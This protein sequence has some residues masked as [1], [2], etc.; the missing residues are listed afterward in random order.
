M[1]PLL[2][3]LLTLA[4]VRWMRAPAGTRPRPGLRAAA[5]VVAMGALTVGQLWWARDRMASYQVRLLG[6][7]F[8][9]AG[10]QSGDRPPRIISGDRATADI[11]V[12][13]IGTRP[14][15]DIRMRA[16]DNGGPPVATL[17]RRQEG[18]LGVVAVRVE[19]DGWGGPR[20]TLL[21]SVALAAGDEIRVGAPGPAGAGG[22]RLTLQ[23]DRGGDRLVVHVPGGDVGRSTSIPYPEGSWVGTRMAELFKRRPSVFQRTYPLTELIQAAHAGD[24]ANSARPGFLATPHGRGLRSFLYY[25]QD[26]P[27]L[28]ALDQGIVVRTRDGAERTPVARHPIGRSPDPQEERPSEPPDTRFGQMIV[29]ALPYRDFPE[30]QLALGERYGIRVQQRMRL[31]VDPDWLTVQPRTEVHAV[32]VATLPDNGIPGANGDPDR[33]RWDLRAL[34]LSAGDG[35]DQRGELLFSSP[36]NRFAGAAQAV[37]HLPAKPTVGWFEIL[38]PSGLATWETGKPFT[39]QDGDRGLL[40]RVDGLGVSAALT[41]LLVALFLLAAAPLALPGIATATRIVALAGIALASLRL[42]LSVSAMVR[43]PFLDEGYRIS[44]WLIPAVPWLL[45][46]AER[47]ALGRRPS[48]NTPAPQTPTAGNPDTGRFMGQ[49]ARGERRML[50]RLWP[51]HRTTVEATVAGGAAMTLAFLA[52]VLFPDSLPKAIALAGFAVVA[53]ALAL[54]L[55]RA[56]GWATSLPSGTVG[57]R[58]RDR[59]DGFWAT[60][61][62]V[63]LP[64]LIFGL[65]LFLARVVLDALGLREQ[66]SLGGTRVGLSVFYTPLALSGFALLLAHHD[67]RIAREGSTGRRRLTAMA[68]VDMGLYLGFAHALTSVWISDYGIAFTTLPGPLLA[69]AWVGWRWARASGPAPALL[70]ALPLVLFI[71]LQVAPDLA[72]PRPAREVDMATRLDDWSRNELLLL[73]R[74]DPDALRLIG[75]SRSEA[76][77][78][79]RETMRSYT[80]GNWAGQGFLAGR[81]S[82]QIRTTAAREHVVTGLLASQWGLLGTLGLVALLATVASVGWPSGGAAEGAAR[83]SAPGVPRVTAG[84]GA[85]L[86]IAL[87]LPSPANSVVLGILVIAGLAVVLMPALV[88]RLELFPPRWSEWCWASAAPAASVSDP[89]STPRAL[90]FTALATFAGAGIYMVLANYGL[91]LFTGKNVYFLGLDSLSDTAEALALV[92]LGVWA[93]ARSRITGSG[94]DP[95]Q[96]G[97]GKT[98]SPELPGSGTAPAL[99]PAKTGAPGASLAPRYGTRAPPDERMKR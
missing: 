56:L 41:A 53:T 26:A 39:L 57:A 51:A 37:L 12:A 42:L 27:R 14:V 5:V 76:L 29:A 84:A 7:R 2:L 98:G 52:L 85:A 24:T 4:G 22:V 59:W 89:V 63:H 25:D 13:G 8:S 45:L 58:V 30:P 43:D 92:G 1:T 66:W 96:P 28:M 23:R 55:P 77:G 91:V 75:E 35:A 87:V 64:G 67:R 81:V 68:L 31:R 44:L 46:V 48:L 86:V 3:A 80:R 54:A 11:H 99:I 49:V 95:R 62:K 40:V 9:A 78:V 94:H 18:M 19:D 60:C 36:G 90:A 71:A 34:H 69:L 21:G 38:A 73:E 33:D 74:G 15:A 61:G 10:P 79:M 47:L 70:G 88:P 20:W 72:R 83:L 32:P 17:Q 82:P 93:T 97:A 65:A 50:A 16:G 6:T